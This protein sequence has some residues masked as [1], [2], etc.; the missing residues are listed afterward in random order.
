[1]GLR[2][3]I[4]PLMV[5]FRKM[6]GLGNDFVVFDARRAPLALDAETV[7]R[8][9]DRRRGIGCDQLIV[10][11]PPR[12]LGTAAWMSIRNPD[13]SEAEACGNATRCVTGL[14]MDEAGTDTVA[15]GTLGGVLRAE[16]RLGGLVSVDMGVPRLR[17]DEVPLARE[18]D[19]L[20]LPLAIDGAADPAACSMGN[21][22][23]TF[24]VADVASLDIAS[25][26]PRLEHDA[27]FPARANIG[28]TEILGAD[29]ILLRMW[30]RGAGI[31]LAC[32]SG[33]CAALVNAHRRGL[34]GRTATVT[35]DGGELL[36]DWAET[37]RVTMTGPV[38]ESFTGEID[39]PSPAQV[40]AA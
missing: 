22:H 9:A 7:R 30:E 25:I 17:W 8:V 28:F 2:A 39:L 27:L 40:R 1:M 21:P 24:F 37:G 35:L 31:T 26:G 15:L 36:I 32:G 6:H 12:E 11:E 29:R 3:P 34:T 19:T 20:H 5:P 38:A 33:A 18:M 4:S 10:I 13:G 14:L 16:R 23:A